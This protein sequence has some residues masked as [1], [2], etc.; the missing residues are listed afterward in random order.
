MKISGIEPE[1]SSAVE[2]ME[3]FAINVKHLD[4]GLYVA[5]ELGFAGSL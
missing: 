2:M 3:G 4:V 5:K 1:S